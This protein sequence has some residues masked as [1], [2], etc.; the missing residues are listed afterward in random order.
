[1]KHCKIALCQIVPVYDLQKNIDHA[2]AMISEAAKNGAN[3][4]A[5][6]EIFYYPYDLGRIRSI[7]GDEPAILTRLSAIAKKEGVVLC[8]GSMA[9]QD[10]ENLY[11]TS[12][13]IDDDGTSV[14]EYRKCHLFDASVGNSRISE[15]SLFSPGESLGVAATAYAKTGL[16]IC[17]DI[18]FPEMARQLALLGAELLLVPAVFN[19]VSGEAHW[20]CFMKTR[21]VENQV[22]LA[23]I[24]Q[25]RSDDS[26]CSYKAYGHSMV[27][28]PWG[29]ILAEA[30]QDE[31]IIY[32]DID[33]ALLVA[34][35]NRLP[36]LQHRRSK[37]YT[38]FFR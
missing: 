25:G 38:S 24:S 4:V 32:A 36:L 5:L 13:L 17:Y 3:I 18:R 19:H 9:V 20:H 7:S 2:V 14:L 21:A 10:G 30:D 34:T 6:P 11:N 1:M 8:I 37:L 27:V 33:P 22:F 35:R 23:A 15:S 16:L 28:S 12:Y 26:R 29:D 31:T